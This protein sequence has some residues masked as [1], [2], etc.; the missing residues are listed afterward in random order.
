M[1]YQLTL[2]LA[3]LFLI[4]SCKKESKLEEEK[5]TTEKRA[6]I[7]MVTS[8]GTILFELYNETPKHRDNFVKLVNEGT[9]DSLLFHRV[10]DQFMIQA[11]DPESKNA[12]PTD[13]L[14]SGGVGYRVD[15]EFNKE[16]FHKRGA[17]GAARDGNPER[18]SSGIQFYIV[19]RGPRND[20]LIDVDQG[21]INGWLAE[22]YMQKDSAYVELYELRNTAISDQDIETYRKIQDSISTLAE[23]YTNFEKYEI[24]EAHR[25]IYRTHGGTSHLDQN[26]TV[27]GEVIEGMDVVD[28]IATVQT[29]TLTDQ[30]MMSEFYL[31]KY[32]I[33]SK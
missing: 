33:R 21:R 30:L 3:L 14:G 11:G 5:L 6:T 28:S 10:I 27:F 19:Q 32:L 24:P 18:A 23:S 15:A 4:V 7:E 20:S 22:H 12:T 16:L 26:Y 1:K 2:L 31:L 8:K 9:L 25:E 29:K 17:I 13:T